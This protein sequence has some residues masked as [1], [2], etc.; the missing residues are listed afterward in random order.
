MTQKMRR[1][2]RKVINI[3]A[4]V[5][6]QFDTEKQQ[7]KHLNMRIA[8]KIHICEYRTVV[9]VKCSIDLK[10][11]MCVLLEFLGSCN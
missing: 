2:T 5:L 8:Q 10:S 1:M 3:Q 9:S 11:N 4:H 6:L 7:K